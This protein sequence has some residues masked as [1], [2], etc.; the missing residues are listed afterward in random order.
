MGE[1]EAGPAVEVEKAE[2]MIANAFIGIMG[3]F[4]LII[5]LSMLLV[6]IIDFRRKCHATNWPHVTGRILLSDFS[7]DE[8][9]DERLWSLSI[10]Y[11]YEIARVRYESEFSAV[12]RQNI[13][14][15]KRRSMES[16]RTSRWSRLFALH[17][18]H[19]KGSG[20]QVYYDPDKPKVSFIERDISPAEVF[21]KL[22]GPLI[23]IPLGGFIIASALGWIEF[24]D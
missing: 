16:K 13:L 7:A 4:I 14:D 8:G 19:P 5:G 9:E 21:E 15:T 23:F 2:E 11:E 17:W 12:C 22:V 24:K 20:V 18:R 10:K 6:E 1:S 3:I